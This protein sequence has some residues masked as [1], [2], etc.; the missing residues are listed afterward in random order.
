M[1]KEQ[2]IE[3]IKIAIETD[4]YLSGKLDVRTSKAGIV[5]NIIYVFASAL[6]V[7]VKMFD[8]LRKEIDSIINKNQIGSES[9][10]VE[11]AYKFQ[12]GDVPTVLEGRLVYE[13]LNPE[14]QIIKRASATRQSNANAILK[15][16]TEDEDGN[17]RGLNNDEALAFNAYIRLVMFAGS[18]VSTR[19]L[20]ADWLRLFGKI[21]Y[22]PIYEINDFKRRVSQGIEAHIK[23]VPF[24]GIFKRIDLVRAITEVEGV[25]DVEIIAF[26]G[27]P[28]TT[29]AT[30][31]NIGRQYITQA[32]YAAIKQDEY[33][34]LDVYDEDD[35][36]LQTG[37][38]QFIPEIATNV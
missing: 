33:P 10:Y 19:S 15:V 22:D 25:R 29:G 26:A 32:G 17:I 34:L 11:Q 5:R 24:D 2:I 23:N 16:A 8:V 35:V 30:W 20:N 9:W 1:T 28:R 6:F 4:E 13:T 14:K 27:L 31:I 18:F 21:Y 38:L 7:V 12:Y 37:T 36:L 3:Q